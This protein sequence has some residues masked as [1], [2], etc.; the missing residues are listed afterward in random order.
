MAIW[1]SFTFYQITR[2]I[3]CFGNIYIVTINNKCKYYSIIITVYFIGF[4][5]LFPSII[6]RIF[7]VDIKPKGIY[8]CY[9]VPGQP[10][11][12]IITSFTYYSWNL[13][14]LYL[15]AKKLSDL[16][17][18]NED[19]KI[20]KKTEKIREFLYKMVFLTISMAIVS[21]IC[22]PIATFLLSEVFSE[23]AYFLWYIFWNFEI[24][25]TSYIQYL[26][27][28]PNHRKYEKFIQRWSEYKC[29]CIC[30]T[31]FVYKSVGIINQQRVSNDEPETSTKT[32]S[33]LP[34][35]IEQGEVI[36][37]TNIQQDTPSP[38]SALG[39][40]TSTDTHH[41]PEIVIM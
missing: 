21:L 37:H 14:V 17:E 26:M 32:Q 41:S 18:E 22:V 39:T 19:G 11:V 35:I 33:S 1:I 7:L 38:I 40:E 24:L 15:Y 5:I 9:F 12:G 3:H 29:C 23:Q 2:F 16:I 28:I 20:G 10:T 13:S 27:I 25:S 6:S 36:T 4:L 31:N 30:R 34:T 8:G